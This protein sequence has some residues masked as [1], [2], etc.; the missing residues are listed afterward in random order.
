MAMM[1]TTF[2][3]EPAAAQQGQT[4][5]MIDARGGWSSNT[6]LNP[7]F[8]EWDRSFRG[9]YGTLSV[10]GQRSWFSASDLL[11][12]T[13]GAVVEPL[14]GG[15]RAWTGGL[16]LGHYQHRFSGKVSAGLEAGG[17]YFGSTFQRTLLWAQPTVTWFPS[18]FTRLR[19]KAG[20]NLRAY[21]NYPVDSV[22]VDSRSRLDLYGVELETWPSFRWQLSAGL[23]GRLNT[24]P[25]IGEGF[26]S[27]LSAGYLF[28]R[29]GKVRLQLGL[30]Q[31][32]NEVTT[33]VPGGGGFPPVGGGGSTTE[34]VEQTTRLWRVGLSG[35]VPVGE[36]VSLFADVEG[37]NYGSTASTG[38]LYD[39]QVSGGVRFT[40]EPSRRSRPGRIAPDWHRREEE[41]VLTLR[42]SG[43]GQLYLVGTFNNWNRPG[44]PLVRQDKN[45]YVAELQLATGAYE[46]KILRVQGGEQQWLEFSEQTYTVDDGFG[47]E[48][49]ML[50]IE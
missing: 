38:Q 2:I 9:S 42:Y 41:Q 3:P 11:E 31:Y 5:L 19:V 22:R 37:L 33:T 50:L 10:L 45:R 44:I 25:S 35:T 40:F 29:G 24:L 15:R 27:S 1:I 34:T 18:A 48:N 6:Y 32:R 4:L 49:A 28:R 12:L 36:R 46:Y 16:A 17:S 14:S 23:Y 20:S 21:R 7:Y 13:G 30:E 47:G 26:S 43:Q 39:L 8:S